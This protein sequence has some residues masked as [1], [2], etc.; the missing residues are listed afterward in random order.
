MTKKYNTYNLVS[1]DKNVQR[2]PILSVMTTTYNTY[3]PVSNDKNV[4]PIPILSPM[5]TT[6]NTNE[7]LA[8][9]NYPS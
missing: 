7:V 2:I 8:A 1:N 6:Y 5:T 4:Q 9:G 3:N